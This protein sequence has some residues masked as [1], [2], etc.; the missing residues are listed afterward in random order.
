ML[1]LLWAMSG[2]G[3]V[4]DAFA[5]ASPACQSMFGCVP[6]LGLAPIDSKQPLVHQSLS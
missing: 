6:V 2:S 5:I 3:F 1:A 4:T